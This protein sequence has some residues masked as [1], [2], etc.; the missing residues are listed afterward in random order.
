M[1]YLNTICMVP[2]YS[3]W[4]GYKQSGVGCILSRFRLDEY[5]EINQVRPN[6][7]GFAR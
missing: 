5:M 4:G 1:T 7:A 3:P 2:T 6:R